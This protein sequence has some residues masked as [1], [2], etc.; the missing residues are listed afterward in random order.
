MLRMSKKRVEVNRLYAQVKPGE[1]HL[2][3]LKPASQ[4]KSEYSDAFIFTTLGIQREKRNNGSTILPQD[5]EDIGEMSR[6]KNY[7]AFIYADGNRMGET[8]RHISGL[9]KE[10]KEAL[11]AQRAFSEIVDQACREAAVEAVLGNV[12]QKEKGTESG[13]ARFIP[14]EFIMA[15]G[16]DLMLVVPAQCALEV[17]AD[18]LDLY[19]E[20][21]RD[22]QKD[23]SPTIGSRSPLPLVA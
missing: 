1:R 14:A 21:T 7:M 13:P 15:G 23:M 12:P 8:L 17:A 4:L 16:D 5:F 3:Q 19:Q 6:P 2:N 9:F 11:Q 20:K 18:F 10:D 22:L